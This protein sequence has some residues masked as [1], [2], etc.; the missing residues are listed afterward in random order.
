MT[1]IERYD[2]KIYNRIYIVGG[3]DIYIIWKENK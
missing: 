2:S 1:K 3:L